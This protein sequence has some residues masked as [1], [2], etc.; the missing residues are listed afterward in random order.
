MPEPGWQPNIAVLH[1][2]ISWS[3]YAERCSFD[4]TALARKSIRSRDSRIDTHTL[5]P[6]SIP[7]NERGQIERHLNSGSER[8]AFLG[9]RCRGVNHSLKSSL[10][11]SRQGRAP[12]RTPERLTGRVK[13]LRHGATGDT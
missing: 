6:N 8:S 1:V 3:R 5:R 9:D 2:E 7:S 13:R 11:T 4:A 12:S 10:F